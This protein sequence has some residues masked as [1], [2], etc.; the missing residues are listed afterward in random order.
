MQEIDMAIQIIDTTAD[1]YNDTWRL[2]FPGL[3][4]F[5]LKITTTHVSLAAI[6][7]IN[8]TVPQPWTK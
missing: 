1:F 3:F 2:L 6:T 4:I 5:L 8:Y 7:Y